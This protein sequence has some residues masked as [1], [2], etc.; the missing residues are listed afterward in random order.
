MP[1]RPDPAEHHVARGL[2]QP[3]ALDHALAVV[4]E[5]ALA[6][7]RLEH[8]RLRLLHLQEQRVVVVAAEEEDDPRPR[9]DAADA[10]DLAGGVDEAEPLE[11][12]AAV[13]LQRPPVRADDAPRRPRTRSSPSASSR[14]RDDQRRVADDPR[15]AV[16][17][18]GELRERR[19]AVLRARLRDVALE[20]LDRLRAHLRRPDACVT[21]STSIREY[22][23]SSVRMPANSAIAS[24][25]ARV[26]ARLIAC[27]ASSRRTRGCGRRPRSSRRAA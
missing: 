1:S 5:L 4:R 11:Q 21:S 3:L 2:H 8:R 20:A 26:T 14:D 27:A 17:D 7:E 15:L 19:E 6:E 9:A 10:D 16:D 13:A 12:V 24:R 22:Q 18:L 25:Y 23:T